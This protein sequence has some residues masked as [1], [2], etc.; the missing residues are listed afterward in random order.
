MGFQG[1]KDIFNNPEAIFRLFS[2]EP[3]CPFDI[4]LCEKGEDFAIAGNHFKLGLYEHQSA[5]AIQSVLDL[6]MKENIIE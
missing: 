5:G 2:K 1:P 4:N 6:I 3:T